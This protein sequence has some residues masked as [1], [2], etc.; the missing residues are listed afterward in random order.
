[1]NIIPMK[2]LLV[3]QDREERGKFA[4]LLGRFGHSVAFAD[5]IG[6]S[7]LRPDDYDLIIVD[8]YL[9]LAS[10]FDFLQ[11]LSPKVRAKTIYLSSGG[12]KERAICQTKT[13][14]YECMGKPVKPMELAVV[15]CDFFVIIYLNN[16]NLAPLS[17]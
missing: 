7:N 1:M 13:G 8:E 16:E 4:I 15:A 9:L 11:H 14:I 5:G 2:I 17:C 6:S 10:G 3:H 12:E